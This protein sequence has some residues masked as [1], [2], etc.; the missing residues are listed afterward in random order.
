M[1]EHDFLHRL[2]PDHLFSRLHVY[3]RVAKH[4]VTSCYETLPFA[5]IPS[6]SITIKGHQMKTNVARKINT[7]EGATAKQVNPEMQLRRSLLSCMLWEKE[8]YEDGQTI[9][10]RIASLADMLPVSTVCALAIEARTDFK[11]RHAPLLLLLSAIR[12]GGKEVGSAICETIQRVDEMAELVSLYWMAGKKPLSKQMKIGLGKAFGKFNEYHF[13]KYNRDGA[14]KL[15]DVLFLVHAKPSKEREDLYKRIA[16]NEL[17]NPDTWES[18][19]AGGED[20]KTVFTDLLSRKKLGALA[21]LRNLRG[22]TECGVDRDLII[23]GIRECQTEKVLPY[24]FI[25]A[26]RY[27]PQFEQHLDEKIIECVAG[28]ERL[29]GKTVLLV[30]VSGSMDDPLSQKSDLRRI[31]AACG[32]AILLREICEDVQVIT[33]SE[34]G[35]M[36]PSRRGMALR[37]AIVNSQPHRGTYLGQAVAAVNKDIQ[38]DRLIVITDEQTADRVPDPIKTAYMINVAS[39]KN[40]VGYASWI[41]IDGF[42]E[43]CIGFIR[44]LEKQDGRKSD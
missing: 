27:A 5:L 9:A 41:H 17:E 35:V 40:G 31:D 38:H 21:L 36:V 2:F 26:A 39:A 15:R 33:F 44:E 25:A 43:A 29:R 42:S 6:V 37:D 11:L 14:V 28:E 8:F 22:M 7:H 4:K 12:R 19:L 1:V 34:Q 24:R 16:N 23:A 30:D 20:K 18:R 10:Q 32:L 3:D 13:A